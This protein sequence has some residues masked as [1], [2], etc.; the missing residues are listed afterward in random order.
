VAVWSPGAETDAFAWK[1]SRGCSVFRPLSP[2]PPDVALE[3]KVAE[4]SNYAGGVAEYLT[5]LRLKLAPESLE[6]ARLLVTQLIELAEE[7]GFSLKDE[8]TYEP[9]PATE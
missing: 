8:R 1:R 2:I 9:E 3:S 7:R 5:D 4:N 6:D